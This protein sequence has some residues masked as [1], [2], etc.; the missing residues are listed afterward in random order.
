MI[1]P[2]FSTNIF[3]ELCYCSN[4]REHAVSNIESLLDTSLFLAYLTTYWETQ[5]CD[6]VPMGNPQHSCEGLN[7][8]LK[9]LQPPF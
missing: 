8:T 5:R 7:C 3:L 2:G 1:I 6:Q 9:H 4:S